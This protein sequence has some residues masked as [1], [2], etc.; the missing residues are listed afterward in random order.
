ML[1]DIEG[2]RQYFMFLLVI[3]SP[4]KPLDIATWKVLRKVKVKGYM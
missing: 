4:P 3:A 2:A 1:H